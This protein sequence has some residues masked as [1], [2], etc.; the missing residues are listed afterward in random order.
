MPRPNNIPPGAFPRGKLGSDVFVVDAGCP[1]RRRR[2]LI[3]SLWKLFG[4]LLQRI[5][6]QALDTATAQR[7]G[8]AE[9]PDTR[10]LQK[11]AGC[12]ALNAVTPLDICIDFLQR[13][14]QHMRQ[15]PP[16]RG[17]VGVVWRER[18]RLRQT[19]QRKRCM[20]AQGLQQLAH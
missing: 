6:Q 18:L 16:T 7:C 1:H 2:R 10:A 20:S 15:E 4:D 13:L 8:F 17:R 9:R 19:A 3:E 11:T 5:R 12:E 14:A